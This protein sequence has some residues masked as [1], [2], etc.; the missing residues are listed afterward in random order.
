MGREHEGYSASPYMPHNAPKNVQ[1]GLH[2]VVPSMQHIEEECIPAGQMQEAPVLEA[3]R[4]KSEFRGLSWDRK[5]EG[6]VVGRA[7][8][9]SVARSVAHYRIQFVADGGSGYTT[10]MW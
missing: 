6:C 2:D 7:V 1:V 9:S 10:G 5:H 4:P 8:A 3:S